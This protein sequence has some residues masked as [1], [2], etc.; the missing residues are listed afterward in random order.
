MMRRPKLLSDGSRQQMS[1]RTDAGRRH[2]TPRHA[3]SRRGRG[4]RR[5]G[6]T[7]MR[8]DARPRRARTIPSKLPSTAQLSALNAN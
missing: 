2:A 6:P 7:A 3:S 5:R 1:Y 8:R 4:T